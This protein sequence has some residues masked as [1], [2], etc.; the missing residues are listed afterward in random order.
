MWVGDVLFSRKIGA[1]QVWVEISRIK[2]LARKFSSL[3]LVS[4]I[5]VLVYSLIA[6]AYSARISELSQAICILIQHSF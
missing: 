2:I 1:N 4:V 6:E 5:T 3:L